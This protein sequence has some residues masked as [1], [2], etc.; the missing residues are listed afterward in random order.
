MPP[1][2]EK[3]R[4]LATRVDLRLTNLRLTDQRLTDQRPADK[5]MPRV[6]PVEHNN[7]HAFQIYII[8]HAR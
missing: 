7:T 8:D 3:E 2:E 4:D 6:L 1:R 5:D